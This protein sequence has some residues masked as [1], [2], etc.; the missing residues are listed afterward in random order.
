MNI[1]ED[2]CYTDGMSKADDVSLSSMSKDDIMSRSNELLT[3]IS[4]AERELEEVRYN[5][6]H[7]DR[8]MKMINNREVSSLR[9]VCDDCHKIVGYPALNQIDKWKHI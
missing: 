1:Y 6:R 2:G 7:N 8:T 3:I 9:I 5:C 4:N